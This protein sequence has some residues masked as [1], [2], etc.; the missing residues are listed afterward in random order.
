MKVLTVFLNAALLAAQQGQPPAKSAKSA[1]SAKE[2]V[3]ALDRMAAAGKSQH[4][5]ALYVFD[6]Q[7]C[8]A[9]HTVGQNGALGYT[10]R[11]KQV[12]G[13][14]EGCVALLTKMNVVAGVDPAKRTP[15]HARTATRFSEFGCTLCHLT[16]GGKLGLTEVGARLT[17]AHLG[18]VEIEK[19]VASKPK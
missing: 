4:E 19:L 1:P 9:C 6:T 15:Q 13:E 17:R 3:A 18:C 8:R 16:T 10:E 11:G 2:T 14:A 12:G 7:G 5:M